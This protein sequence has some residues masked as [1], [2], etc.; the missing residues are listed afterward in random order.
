MPHDSALELAK[1]CLGKPAQYDSVYD[2]AKLLAIPRSGNRLDIGI[3]GNQLPFQG[4]DVWN[5]YEVSWLNEKGKPLAAM[6]EI[7]LPCDSPHI[8]ESKTMKLYFNTLNNTVFKDENA[9]QAVVKNDLETHVG[10]SVKVNIHLLDKKP[11]TIVLLTGHCI[12][13]LD[14]ECSVY[15]V[16]PTFLITENETTEEVLYS[17]LLKSN[18]LVT[19]QPDWGSVQ[20]AYKGKKINYAGL[21]RYIVSFRHHNEFAEHCVERIF[22]DVMQRCQPQELTVI[23]RYTRRGGLDINPYRSTQ[24]LAFEN[25]RLSRQ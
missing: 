18:C 14:I 10:A 25:G 2:P 11:E 17:H 5:H 12:D 20:I 22:M 6:A 21:L 8:I 13:D 24:P 23:G 3:N 4:F 1:S 15:T 7:I 16:D 9:L 19:N